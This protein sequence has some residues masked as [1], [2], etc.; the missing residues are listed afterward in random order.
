ME[1]GAV[2]FLKRIHEGIAET[3]KSQGR[4]FGLAFV[5]GISVKYRNSTKFA[6]RSKMLGLKY[7]M[8]LVTCKDMDSTYYITLLSF[9]I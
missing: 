4:W 5:A 3:H 7:L 9:V 6:G 2:C 8:C 1:N